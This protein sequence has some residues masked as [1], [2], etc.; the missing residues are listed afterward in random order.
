M[1]P[2]IWKKPMDESFDTAIPRGEFD[3]VFDAR[4]DRLHIADRASDTPR[5]VNISQGRIFPPRHKQRKVIVGSS[6]HPAIGWIYLVKLFEA[7]LAQNS[8]KKLMGKL[9]LIVL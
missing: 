7:A 6:N 1:P 4:S 2:P 5:R 3:H 9:S 8:I